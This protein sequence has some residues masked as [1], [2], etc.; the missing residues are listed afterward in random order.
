[1]VFASVVENY[2][3]IEV[4]FNSDA[5]GALFN[6]VF[7]NNTFIHSTLVAFSNSSSLLPF[8]L[9]SGLYIIFVHDIEHEGTLSS[10]VGYPAVTNTLLT[11]GDSQGK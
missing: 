10:G 6:F 2:N 1:M 11:V 5:R 3:G 4:T 9:F 8:R 7:T